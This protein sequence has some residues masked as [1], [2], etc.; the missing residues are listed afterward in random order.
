ME[1]CVLRIMDRRLNR[2]TDRISVCSKMD[3]VNELLYD[4][5]D[6]NWDSQKL[7]SLLNYNDIEALQAFFTEFKSTYQYTV[8]IQII[9]G[10]VEGSN[11]DTIELDSSEVAV[12][13]SALSR[14]R[15]AEL[16]KDLG[17]D[18]DAIANLINSTYRK[19]AD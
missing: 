1:V 13:L 9:Q 17:Q 12:T 15:C 5:V 8:D 3:S 14:A 16:G 4:F 19:L 2:S 7:G 11:E 6:A 18:K 10:G